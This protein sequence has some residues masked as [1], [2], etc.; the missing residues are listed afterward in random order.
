M[1]SPKTKIQAPR[2]AVKKNYMPPVLRDWG[3]LRDV[4]LTAGFSGSADGGKI[5]FTRTRL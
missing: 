5:L 3:T 4:T 1:K 2:P